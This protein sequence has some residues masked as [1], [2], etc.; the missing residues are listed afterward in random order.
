MFYI[1]LRVSDR[2]NDVLSYA[3]ILP[4]TDAISLCNI[5]RRRIEWNNF[6]FYLYIVLLSKFNK[7]YIK[8]SWLESSSIL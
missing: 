4:H 7:T 3:D 8:E 5:S 1:H 6:N 2:N